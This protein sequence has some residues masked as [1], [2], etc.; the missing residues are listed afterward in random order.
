MPF[1]IVHLYAKDSPEAIASTQKALAEAAAV[2]TQ[3]EGTLAWLPIQDTADKRAFAVFEKF[4]S[5]DALQ[6]H[7]DHS[8]RSQFLGNLKDALERPPQQAVYEKL[9]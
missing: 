2:Y 3:D 9:A 8:Y 6:A 5:E 7:R 1:V 4:V